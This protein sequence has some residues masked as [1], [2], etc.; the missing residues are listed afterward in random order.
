MIE[1]TYHTKGEIIE[2]RREEEVNWSGGGEVGSTRGHPRGNTDMNSLK[3]IVELKS[4]NIEGTVVL[5][6]G[7]PY[8][9]M[10]SED[11]SSKIL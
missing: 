3:P 7:T 10:R 5:I 2:N 1:T 8:T 6:D 9:Q 11:T 4:S